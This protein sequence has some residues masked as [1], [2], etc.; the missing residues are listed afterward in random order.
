MYL[1]LICC[2]TIKKI[3]ICWFYPSH[4]FLQIGSTFTGCKV[5]GAAIARGTDNCHFIF[6]YA[7]F[8]SNKVSGMWILVVLHLM[9]LCMSFS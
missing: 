3:V 1:L 4:F 6:T 9:V 7:T 8:Y 5:N 2:F